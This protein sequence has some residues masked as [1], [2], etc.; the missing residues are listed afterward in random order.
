MKA[1]PH[2][3]PKISE[4]A[5]YISSLLGSQNIL[6]IMGGLALL[7]LGLWYF[8]L[9]VGGR[10]LYGALK[11]TSG[12]EF[13]LPGKGGDSKSAAISEDRWSL[14]LVFPG[15]LGLVR[16]AFHLVYGLF[17]LGLSFQLA[18]L[19]GAP[20]YYFENPGVIVAL[21]SK[22]ASFVASQLTGELALLATCLILWHA[23]GV[24][25][26]VFLHLPT[27]ALI[28]LFGLSVL[29]Y[30]YHIRSIDLR[31]FGF[32]GLFYGIYFALP[33]II[34]EG[35]GEGDVWVAATLGVILDTVFEDSL[36]VVLG[37]V[38]AFL[39]GCLGA[40]ILQIDRILNN[41]QIKKGREG[42]I[43]L[44]PF[45]LVGLVIASVYHAS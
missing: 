2:Q 20:I 14:R 18:Y 34:H 19:L 15:N 30:Y 8:V 11:G 24:L 27:I 32:L 45:M 21:D 36:A 41:K 29:F 39:A 1:P 35:V 22:L 42:R 25:D 26:F 40:L 6:V 5:V 9:L 17:L 37:L 10:V 38:S 44:V 33:L 4:I 13:D 43:A 31:P 3:N 23:L 16:L 28:V 12:F 7:A